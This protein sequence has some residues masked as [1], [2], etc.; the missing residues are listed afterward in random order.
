MTISPVRI[1]RAP[2]SLES[3]S[4]SSCPTAMRILASTSAGPAVSRMTSLKPQS[5]F[6]AERAPSV[7]IAMMGQLIPV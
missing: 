2:A 1:S 6:M 4:T 3:L 7:A 5:A